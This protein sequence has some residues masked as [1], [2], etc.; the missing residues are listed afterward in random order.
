MP[1]PHDRPASGTPRHP[2]FT[3]RF[4][5]QAGA[6]GLLG[7]ATEHLAALRTASASFGDAPA[8]SV[9]FIF[10]S[11]GLAQHDSFDPKPDAPEGIRGEFRPIATR[12]PGVHI[13]EHLPLLAARSHLWSMVRSLTHASNDHSAGHHIMLT[14]RSDLPPGFDPNRPRP[15]D[16]PSIAAV[17]GAMAASRNNLPP[18]IVLPERLIHSTGRVIPGQF[19]GVMGAHRDPWFVE[20]SPYDPTAYGAFPEFEFDHQQRPRAP[21]RSGFQAP[22]LTLPEGLG[23]SRL[24]G[25]LDLLAHLDRQRAGLDRAAIVGRFDARRQAAVSLLTDGRIRRAFDVSGADPRLL[26]QYGR[27]SF[28][29]SLL[30][31][32]RLVEAGVSLVQVNLGNDETWDTHGNAFPHLKDKLLPPT[33]RAVSAL[34]DDLH[35]SGLLD[36]TLVVMAGEFG[37]TPRIS[38]LPSAYKLPGR[39]HWGRVQT[40]FLAGGGVVGG[41]VIGSSDRI[42]G[43][44]ASDPQTP[45]N[46]AATI[47]RS[48][49][50]PALATWQD[51]L[52]RPHQVYQGVPIGGLA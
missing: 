45:E 30:M 35:G 7:L 43:H 26:D 23:D 37:R 8:R 22:D 51:E 36:S 9:I 5:L 24:S 27:N 3:R 33:D 11:G 46:L 39:D 41:R 12:T 29:W 2:A 32:R 42:G 34:L 40:V 18:A 44:P 52:E 25:R 38:T 49:G 47:Y 20:A 1:H 6:V 14:G 21:K 31:A 19:A 48:L 28:G 16:W 13:C 10:L 17:A 4:A 15:A 50:I